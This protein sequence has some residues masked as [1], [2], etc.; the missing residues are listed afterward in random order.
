MTD[1]SPTY[2]PVAGECGTN[3]YNPPSSVFGGDNTAPGAFP[4]LA[5]LGRYQLRN[6]NVY[7]NGQKLRRTKVTKWVCGGSL[8][9]HWYVVTAGHCRP[10]LKILRLGEWKVPTTKIGGESQREDVGLQPVQD[11]QL[12]N[13]NLIRHKAAP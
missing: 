4:W 12:R 11:F 10:R 6:S 2:L 8:I 3:P 9:N 1:H 13:I 5:L 7:Q